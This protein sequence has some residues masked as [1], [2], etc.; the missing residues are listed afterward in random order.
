MKNAE[1]PADD[2]CRFGGEEFVI[3]LPNTELD[4]AQQVIESIRQTICTSVVEIDALRLNM[5][6][7]AGIAT[8]VIEHESQAE[9]LFKVADALLYEAKN[10]GRNQIKAAMITG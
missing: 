1:R 7:S 10:A 6:I 5:T 3:L 8:R 2:I 9:D 4:G